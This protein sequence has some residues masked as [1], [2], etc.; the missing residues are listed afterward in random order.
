[1]P[2]RDLPLKL[3]RRHPSDLLGVCSFCNASMNGR[4]LIVAGRIEI[5][6]RGAGSSAIGDE[7]S[8]GERWLSSQHAMKYRDL[9]KLLRDDGWQPTSHDRQPLS[10]SSIQ[11]NRA[12]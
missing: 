5:A 10:I 7:G 3:L 8:G 4:S 6:T 9:L 1:M 11:P 12:S 2:R